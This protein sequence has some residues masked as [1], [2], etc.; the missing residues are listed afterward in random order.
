MHVYLAYCFSKNNVSLKKGLA[1]K[2][3]KT[4]GF[5]DIAPGLHESHFGA[6]SHKVRG[7]RGHRTVDQADIRIN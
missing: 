6:G 5:N 4:A 2:Q 1:R 7:R 3:A